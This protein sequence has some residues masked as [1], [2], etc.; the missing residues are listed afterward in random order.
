MDKYLI[1]GS[2]SSLINAFLFWQYVFESSQKIY[3]LK[4]KYGSAKVM[5][6]L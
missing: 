4:G 6:T 1:E 2:V 3:N 5:R